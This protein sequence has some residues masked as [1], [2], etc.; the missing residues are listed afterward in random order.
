MLHDIWDIY[1][2]MYI[3]TG[4]KTWR[5]GDSNLT[6]PPSSPANLPLGHRACENCKSLAYT[7]ICYEDSVG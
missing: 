4:E 3:Y 5:V 6:F 2:Y 7:T 1:I